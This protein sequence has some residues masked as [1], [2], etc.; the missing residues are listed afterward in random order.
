MSVADASPRRPEEDNQ[1]LS[2]TDRLLKKAGSVRTLLGGVQPPADLPPE[3][4]RYYGA[5]W[6]VYPLASVIHVLFFVMFAGLGAWKLA[7]FNVLSVA[8]WI[9]AAVLHH[10]GFLMVGFVVG[11]GEMVAHAV[12]ATYYL[13]WDVGFYFYLLCPMSGVSLMRGRGV[14]KAFIILTS[15]GVYFAIY[16]LLRNSAPEIPVSVFLVNL[17]YV[18]NVVSAFTFLAIFA[19]YFSGIAGQLEASLASEYERSDELLRNILPQE[20]AERLKDG[21]TTIADRFEMV[22]VLFADISGFTELSSTVTPQQLV[23]MLNDVFSRIDELAA[24]Y[25]LEKIK[26]IGDAYMVA[27]GIPVSREDHA[28]AIADFALDLLELLSDFEEGSLDM[29]IGIHSGPVVAGV[30]GKSKFAYD[31]WGDTVNTAA[32]MESHGVAGGIQVSKVTRDLLKHI[33]EFEDR[34]ELEVKGKG[35]MCTYL[36]RGKV[37]D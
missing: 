5:G 3:D 11:W 33:F 6:G 9:V 37:A 26:T 18:G 21:E 27:A 36:L 28:E 20:I 10:R 31:M 19:N 35:R 1:D 15:A 8:L 12:V 23:R 14:F 17:F 13:G 34:G 4:R 25:G 24:R 22:S 29:R 2:Q 16:L 30:I 7:A 32:R